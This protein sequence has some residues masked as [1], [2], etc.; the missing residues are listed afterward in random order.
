MKRGRKQININE[1]SDEELINMI[2]NQINSLN[3]KIKLFKQSGI[4]EH[5]NYVRSL[6]SE[7]M[8]QYTK[9]GT[10]SKSKKFLKTKNKMWLKKSLV[11]LRK[12][13]NNEVYGTIKKYREFNVSVNANIKSYVE[14]YLLSKG[15]DKKFVAEVT[16]SKE[17]Y[18]KLFDAF[19]N[20]DKYGS[21]QIIEKV[22]LSY[23]NTGFSSAEKEKILSNIEF[24]KNVMDRLREEQQA[25][26]EFKKLRSGRRR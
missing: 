13:N 10:I 1:L 24:S 2:I 9:T 23:E 15:Y 5:Y 21:D 4:D 18:V 14:N 7:D 11:A 16:S 19:K 8:V 3:K 20:N 25:F 22:A 17:F 26:E 12:I 6:L